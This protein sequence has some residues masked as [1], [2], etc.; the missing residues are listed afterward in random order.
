MLKE[1][2]I[3]DL[4]KIN[5]LNGIIKE[6]K[7]V[8]NA[9]KPGSKARGVLGVLTSVKLAKGGNGEEMLSFVGDLD[10]EVLDDLRQK[11]DGEI[12][13]MIGEIISCNLAAMSRQ[14]VAFLNEMIPVKIVH[15][16]QANPSPPAEEITSEDLMAI[17]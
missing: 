9:T 6:W 2:H 15:E 10:P 14:V 7:E 13:A 16:R 4:N 8:E 11:P 1:L 12:G 17:L 3:D 5:K